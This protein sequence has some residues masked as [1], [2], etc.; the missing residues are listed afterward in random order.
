M[1]RKGPF[2]PLLRLSNMLRGPDGFQGT[3]LPLDGW[4]LVCPTGSSCLSRV[5]GCLLGETFL[6]KEP[7]PSF[8]PHPLSL[9][10]LCKGKLFSTQLSPP[11]HGHKTPSFFSS[12]ALYNR[13]TKAGPWVIVSYRSWR[14]HWHR[15]LWNYWSTT[16]LPR[17][18]VLFRHRFNNL[19]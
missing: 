14:K 9:T 8:L 6:V 11:S 7:S 15:G 1:G 3:L 18:Y 5:N 13:A 16:V 19:R 10:A 17:A 2:P 4:L 12:M